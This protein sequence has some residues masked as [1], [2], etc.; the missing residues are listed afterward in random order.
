MARKKISEYKA[1]SLLYKFLNKEYTGVQIRLKDEKA[2]DL[3]DSSKSYVIKV[4]QGIKKRMKNGLMKVDLKSA[5]IKKF[6]NEISKKGYDQFLVEEV[7]PHDQKDE[8]YFSLERTRE[9]IQMYYST[10]GGIDVEENK[11]KIKS[12]IV[13]SENAD[14]IE[15]E[16]GIP[17]GFISKVLD[18]FEKD[19][20]SFLE[21]NP[22]VIQ[23]DKAC[24][25]DL[26][27]M[28][29]STGEYFVNGDWSEEDFI[30]DKNSENIP[31]VKNIEELAEKSTASF[32]I[33]ILNP[34]GSIFMLLSGGGASIVLADEAYQ[35]GFKDELANYGEY[36]G[37]PN[38]EETFIY[39]DN[40]ISLMLK[41]KS[42]KKVLIISGG[43][44]NFTDVY[45]TFQGIIQAMDKNKIEMKKQNVK[46][47]VRRGGPNQDKGLAAI[48]DYMDKETIQNEVYSP[49]LVLTEIVSKAIV[50]LK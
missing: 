31:E 21:I 18:F 13:S 26:A 35:L 23:N 20:V 50:Y 46:V 32:R 3:L 30:K 11:D 34:N 49:D 27:V 45:K 29:D 4:D 19:F 24:V 10:L 44:A 9:G 12:Y 42:E 41:S 48:K 36:S 37:N 8:R 22:L 40:V 6:I 7:V 47:F 33:N 25:L 1:K 5:E 17:E 2:L 39:T 16:T 28:V 43:V 14:E 15:K 38:T